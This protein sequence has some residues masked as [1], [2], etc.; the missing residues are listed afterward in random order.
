MR[1]PRRLRG[2][3]LIELLVV[4]AII[5]ILIA[6]L[7]PAVQQARE[8][9]RRTQCRNNLKQLGLALHNYHDNFL[10][11]PRHGPTACC[12]GQRHSVFAAMLPYYDQAPLAN[13][14]AAGGTAASLNGTTNY[15]GNAF[16]P[17]DQNHRGPTTK[18]PALLC[19]SDSDFPF[20]NGVDNNGIVKGNNYVVCWGD[21]LWETTPQWNGNSQRGLRGMFVGGQ[22]VAGNRSVRDVTDGLSN[23]IAMSECIKTKTLQAATIREGGISFEFTQAQMAQ[24]AGN[25]PA[26]CL[27]GINATTGRINT[28]GDNGNRRGGR[29]FDA[30]II[31]TGF[32]TILGPNKIS[33]LSNNGG[34]SG[35]GVVNPASLHTGGVHCLMGDGAVKF[36]SENIDAGN[37]ALTNPPNGGT[38][39]PSGPSVYGLWGALGSV[40]GG[41]TVG[42]F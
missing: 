40:A 37:P 28:T 5:A 15:A 21:T 39:G 34:D 17:W 3:T 32:N 11:F 38:A 10:M 4:I 20:R 36:V 22:G 12:G 42:D 7:L 9:A 41:E 24:G 8:A 33:C 18:I 35:D 1:V 16:V 6:L 13:L 23:T 14:V 29:W 31:F 27:T 30:N 2:F 25:S 19:P 26:R